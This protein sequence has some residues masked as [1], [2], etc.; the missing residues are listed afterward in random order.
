MLH[1]GAALPSHLVIV[2]VGLHRLPQEPRAEQSEGSHGRPYPPSSPSGGTP[3]RAGPPSPH[4]HRTTKTAAAVAAT[5][6]L[7]LLGGNLDETQP[8]C[9]RRSPSATEVVAVFLFQSVDPSLRA[10]SLTERTHDLTKSF[11]LSSTL[12]PLHAKPVS[13][14]RSFLATRLAVESVCGGRTRRSKD[15]LY[16]YLYPPRSHSVW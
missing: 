2:I 3:H 8:I 10:R 1:S 6:A 15:D 11:C 16:L 13:N 7:A 14:P 12:S 5:E 4:H 9:G